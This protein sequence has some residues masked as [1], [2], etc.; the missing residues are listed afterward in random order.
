VAQKQSPFFLKR[1]ERKT[2]EFTFSDKRSNPD[3]EFVLTLRDLTTLDVLSY[4]E[5]AEEYVKKFVTGYGEAGQAGFVP[6]TSLPPIDSEPLTVTPS[7]CRVLACIEMAQVQP[8][9]DRYGFQELAAMTVV[10][11]IQAQML[12]AFAVIQP[13]G[14]VEETEESPFAEPLGSS[15]GS[16][17]EGSTVTQN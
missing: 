5:S 17:S 6:A 8:E 16:P 10:P 2:R 9:A 13:L 7:T 11:A 4:L 12:E 14:A 1:P 15:S 3:N